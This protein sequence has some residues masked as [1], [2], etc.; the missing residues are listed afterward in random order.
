VHTNHFRS[1]QV[2]DDLSIAAAPSSPVRLARLQTL[3]M[4]SST[5]VTVDVLAAAFADHAN[6]PRSVCYHPDSRQAT[7][8]QETTAA[9]VVMDLGA[10]RL[11]IADGNPCVVPYRTVEYEHVLG[12]GATHV[13]RASAATAAAVSGGA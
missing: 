5:P 6:Y 13:E 11:R 8:E 1:Q 10:R 2:T 3:V 12:G 9:S 7:E 4:E